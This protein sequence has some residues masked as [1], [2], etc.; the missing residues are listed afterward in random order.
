[1]MGATRQLQNWHTWLLGCDRRHYRQQNA[2]HADRVDYT[3]LSDSTQSTKP[4]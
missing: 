3:L 2:I 4:Y 1:M